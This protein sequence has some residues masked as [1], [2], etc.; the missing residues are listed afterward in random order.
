MARLYTSKH[1][2][3]S[4]NPLWMKLLQVKPAVR[5]NGSSNGAGQRVGGVLHVHRTALQHV[6]QSKGES[7]QCSV[8]STGF[9]SSRGAGTYVDTTLNSAQDSRDRLANERHSVEEAGLADEDVEKLLVNLD[10]L[11]GDQRA[12]P[13]FRIDKPT[14]RKE[15]KMMSASFP[16]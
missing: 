5:I 3:P 14:V 8:S 10:E 15:S 1:S 11:E 2:Q 7:L 12:S 4:K 16:E 13:S 6:D 9:N